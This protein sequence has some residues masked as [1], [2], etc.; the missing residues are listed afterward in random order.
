MPKTG[1]TYPLRTPLQLANLKT[2][3]LPGFLGSVSI[4]FLGVSLFTIGML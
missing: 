4:P 2:K 1:H 3:I